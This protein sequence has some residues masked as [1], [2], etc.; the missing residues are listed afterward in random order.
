MLE[1]ITGTSDGLSRRPCG[2]KKC[3]R[4]DCTPVPGYARKFQAKRN[5][6]KRNPIVGPLRSGRSYQKRH[7]ELMEL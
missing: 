1:S 3:T 5:P 6:A 4:E 2:D 7:Q